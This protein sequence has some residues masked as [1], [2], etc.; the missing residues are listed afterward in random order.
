MFGYVP[1]GYARILDRLQA[2]LEEKGI[3]IRVGRAARRVEPNGEGGVRVSFSDGGHE[4]FTSAVLTMPAPVAASL[5]P[6]LSV[7]EKE[8]LN[9]VDYQGIVCASLLL[10]KPLA[11]YY[12]TNIT[13]DGLPFTGVIEMTALVDRTE[14]GG[15]SL[16]YLPKYVAPQDPYFELSD[17]DIRA[18]CVSGLSRMYPQFCPDDIVSF[19]VSR[20]RRVFAL[21]TL[22][23]SSRLPNVCTSLPGVYILNYAHIVNGTLNVDET[24]RLARRGMELLKPMVSETSPLSTASVSR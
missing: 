16:V 13:D 22:D 6:A 15:H 10:R 1:G 8:R 20:V 19:R 11:D 3:A 9:G 24:V 17:E 23:Y 2:R 5:C 12:V 7:T 14:F 4:N 21:P 18:Q